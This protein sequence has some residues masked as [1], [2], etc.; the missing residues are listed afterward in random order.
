MMRARPSFIVS[1]AV[2]ALG[3]LVAQTVLAQDSAA[4]VAAA[5]PPDSVAAARDLYAS[6]AYEE[7]LA[8]LN[9]LRAL[10]QPPDQAMTIEQYRAF[11]LLALGRS[12]EAQ[13]AIETIVVANPLF[14]PATDEMSPRVRTAFSDVRRRLLPGIVQQRYADAKAAFDRKDYGTAARG[15]SDVLA[16]L[17]D[18]DV[19]AAASQPPLSDIRTLA[20]GFSE[21]SVKAI[22]PPPPAPEPVKPVAAATPPPAPAPPRI[23][24]LNDASVVPPVAIKQQ[25]PG[26]TGT[27]LPTES[28]ALEVVIDE[29]GM[30]E[31]ATMRVGVNP[32]YDRQIVTAASHWRYQPAMLDGKPVK[33]RKIIQISFKAGT[34]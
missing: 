22:A 17:N 15:F 23:Y 2:T 30:V 13:S 20:G 5:P 26:F 29:N 32:A 1:A 27:R 11:C 18:P 12:S 21:L 33:F 31:S 25:M 16:V 6:A 9:R 8:V 24:A 10:G 14:R 28:G 19:G 7:S 4:R 3:L 34:P